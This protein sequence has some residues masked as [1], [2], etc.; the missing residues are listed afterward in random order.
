ML[1]AEFYKYFKKHLILITFFTVIIWVVCMRQAV[2]SSKSADIAN[3]G[4]LL[5][6]ISRNLF[7]SVAVPAYIIIISR[8]AGEMEQKNNNWNLLLCMPVKKHRIFLVKIFALAGMV[9]ILYVSYITSVLLIGGIM[10]QLPIVRI[11]LEMLL[12]FVCTFSLISFFYVLSLEKIS[13]IIYLGIGSLIL[14]SGFLAMQ[15][16]RIWTYF[17]W[18]YATV[19]TMVSSDAKLVQYVAINFVLTLAICIMGLLRFCKREW[20]S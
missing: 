1:R 18:C 5:Y 12:S 9:L 17:P 2:L 16:E 15:S 6:V 11:V 13:T 3:A 7:C 14:L 10:S 20:T 4:L 8:I 19:I